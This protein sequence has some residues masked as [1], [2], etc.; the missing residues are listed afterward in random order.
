M[1]RHRSCSD[2]RCATNVSAI[3]RCLIKTFTSVDDLV[4][5]VVPA[6]NAELTIQETLL[7][8][9]NQS[10]QNLEIIIVDDGSRDRTRELALQQATIDP[11]IQVISQPNG[12][13]AVARNQ[14]IELARGR[15]IAPIDAD[16]LWRPGKIERQLRALHAGGPLVGLVYCWSAIINEDSAVTSPGS[17]V[18]HTGDVLLPLFYGNFVGN[19][20]APL[21][22]R[23]MVLAAGG[24]DP[25][26]KARKA[27]GCEDW[28]L[29]LSLAESSH[30]TVI[31]DYLVGYR[32][33]AAAM[34]GDVSQMLRS[35]AIVRG[36]MAD[37]HPNSKDDLTWGRR[38][39]LDWLLRRELEALNW[40]NCMTLIR[41]RNSDVHL[42]RSAARI[43]KLKAKFMRRKLRRKSRALVGS[44][45]LVSHVD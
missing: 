11:R 28:K 9:R 10:H 4:S 33:T 13:V 6:Y 19:G 30:F 22:R 27:Q 14:G 15:L 23:D 7:S 17:N 39:Y 29:Y 31:P 37:R 3:C 42:V 24:Y 26:L 32:F 45:F 35:D 20:S 44:P 21:M 38:H 16:D 1:G 18:T 41:E 2:F 43:A 36:E 40:Q 8:I 34:S 25:S 5:V 12:G